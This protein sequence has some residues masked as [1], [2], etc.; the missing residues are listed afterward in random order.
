MEEDFTKMSDDQLIAIT[1]NPSTHKNHQA[2]AAELQRRQREYDNNNLALQS[3]NLSLQKWIL[4]ATVLAVIIAAVTLAFV[5]VQF[6]QHPEKITSRHEQTYINSTQKQ[7][8]NELNPSKTL[9]PLREIRREE[10]R[11]E[12][13]RREVKRS[14]VKRSET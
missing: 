3:K 7:L 8:Q 10:K 11:R 12:E 4:R 9:E 6:F 2:A 1:V 13:K 5:V 14:E